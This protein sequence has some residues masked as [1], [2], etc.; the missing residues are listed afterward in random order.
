MSK[1]ASAAEGFSSRKQRHEKDDLK[2][3][4]AVVQEAILAVED[5]SWDIHERTQLAE[6]LH[7]EQPEHPLAL[8]P[9]EHAQTSWAQRFEIVDGEVVEIVK[10]SADS[11]VKVI[12]RP[13]LKGGAAVDPGSALEARL[14]APADPADQP[15]E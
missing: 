9:G 11:P 10:E 1:A 3:L 15:E 2:G 12:H 6:E 7:G 13:D 5:A 14:Q 8:E 4:P